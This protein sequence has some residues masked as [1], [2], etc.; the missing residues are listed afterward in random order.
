LILDVVM[1][2]VARRAADKGLGHVMLSIG[3]SQKPFCTELL[4]P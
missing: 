2:M 1:V 4:T 3:T